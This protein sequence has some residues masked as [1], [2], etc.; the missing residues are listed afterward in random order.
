MCEKHHGTGIWDV[1]AAFKM[2][3]VILSYWIS[4]PYVTLLYNQLP[5][6]TA[7]NLKNESHT[8]E[9]LKINDRTWLLL[10]LQISPSKIGRQ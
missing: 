1:I 6:V 7:S 10:L 2:T 4:W 9:Q 8:T 3:P 5:L